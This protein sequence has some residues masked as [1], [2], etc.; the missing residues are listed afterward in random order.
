MGQLHGRDMLK[1]VIYSIKEHVHVQN[2]YHRHKISYCVKALYIMVWRG[3]KI[4]QLKHRLQQYLQYTD[5][6]GANRE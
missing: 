6:K 5:A 4:T 1:I 2:K 3:Y